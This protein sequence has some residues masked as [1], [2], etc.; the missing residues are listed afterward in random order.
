MSWLRNNGPC[1]EATWKT[2]LSSTTP[3]FASANAF[4]SSLANNVSSSVSNLSQQAKGL[5]LRQLSEQ[6]KQW[7]YKL[8]ELPKA[9]DKERDAF[10]K[11]KRVDERAHVKG[12]EPLAPWQGLGEYEEEL[13]SRVLALSRNKR[14]FIMPPPA[15]STWTEEVFRLYTSTAIAALREDPHLRKMRFMLVPS[16]VSEE[17]F[18]SNYFYRVSLIKHA[19]MSSTQEVEGV[20]TKRDEEE[21]G[22]VL[23]EMDHDVDDDEKNGLDVLKDVETDSPVMST[24]DETDA[25]PSV[26]SMEPAQQ[27]APTLVSVSEDTAQT[28]RPPS[29]SSSVKSFILRTP[30]YENAADYASNSD[31]GD[32]LEESSGVGEGLEEQDGYAFKGSR[33]DSLHRFREDRRQQSF[34][35]DSPNL[36]EA[37]QSR[38]NSRQG[39]HAPAWKEN[40]GGGF[41]RDDDDF[42]S[43]ESSK[44]E[45]VP[46]NNSETS[47][48]Q[49][50]PSGLLRPTVTI[51]APSSS[52]NSQDNS[53]PLGE[54]PSDYDSSS[55]NESNPS[56]KARQIN[57]LRRQGSR[58]S[59]VTRLK[60]LDLNKPPSQEDADSSVW[61]SHSKHF[62]VLSNA[63]KPI[64]TR[65]GDESRI[66]TLMGVIQ[67]IISFFQDGD[68]S[69][70]C[71]QSG[72]TV[73][74][75]LLKEPLYLVAVAKTGESEGQLREQLYY[76]YNQILSVLTSH[77]LNRIFEQRINFDLRRLLGGT[78]V[79]LDSLSTRFNNNHGFMLGAIQALAVP[80]EFRD[81]VGIA[82]STGIVKSLLYGMVVSNGKL[83]NLVRPKKHSLHPS[84]LHLLFNMLT[85]STTFRSAESWTPLCLPK[86]NSKGFLHAYICYIYQDV[87]LVLIS[88]DKDSFFEL[89]EWKEDIVEVEHWARC[90]TN[91]TIAGGRIILFRLFRLY[92]HMRDHMCNKNQPLKLYYHNSSDE[93][94]LGWIT[95]T[96]ELY[97]CFNPQVSKSSMIAA[98]NQLIRWIRKHEERLFIVNSPVF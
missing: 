8:G 68:D 93:T 9:L 61:R 94:L 44:D 10:V 22:D 24:V 66:S 45:D 1:L 65:Y 42:G 73:F 57:K 52:S 28:Y 48:D 6:A 5:N 30:G 13:K 16:I 19:V 91:V 77:Q 40:S 97:A 47:V 29:A 64:W 39:N 18:W 60:A 14:N 96:F 58:S 72:D 75:F 83:V 76:L 34:R 87:A 51:T 55:S 84:D 32:A 50:S 90:R 20:Y 2:S 11:E 43:V 88:T 62:F 70:R 54:Q 4:T 49:S 46:Y 81:K 7:P 67:A 25:G 89:S 3:L 92:Q 27:K 33:G 82:L 74:V 12:S 79:F 23:F 53:S 69:I 37:S 98:A 80:R 21:E 15:D 41:L 59:V 38:S 86:F 35:F 85:G 63:G 17:Q 56:E 95:S 26:E 31:V 78:E 71:I 36:S